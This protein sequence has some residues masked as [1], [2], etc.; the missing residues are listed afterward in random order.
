MLVMGKAEVGWYR[1]KWI[2]DEKLAE[3]WRSLGYEVKAA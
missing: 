2:W 1:A 3:H